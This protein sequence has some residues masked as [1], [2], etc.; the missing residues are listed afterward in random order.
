[1]V[2]LG[3]SVAILLFACILTP[4]GTQLR[5][6]QI[7]LPSTCTFKLVTGLPCPG[8]GLTRSLVAA[9]HGNWRQ[10][11]TYHRMGPVFLILL[12]L[13]SL[14]RITWMGLPRLRGSVHRYGRLLDL[15]IIP[16]MVLLFVNW[17]PTLV[18]AVDGRWI[19]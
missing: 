15:A 12:V 2:V 4:E 10:S 18:S 7:T 16:L 3:V 1:M 13:Q 5:L 19:E 9:A 14:Y 8:C 11:V 17:I 6:G